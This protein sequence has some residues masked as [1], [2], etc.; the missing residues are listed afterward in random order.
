MKVDG[1]CHCGHLTYEAE[2]DESIVTVCHCTDCQNLAGTPFRVTA[3]SFEGSFTLLTGKP[4]EYVKT[5]GSGNPRIQAFCAECGSQ[6]YSTSVGEGPKVYNLRVG[7][8]RQRDSLVPTRQIW[9]RSAHHWIDNL[10]SVPMY[11][12]GPPQPR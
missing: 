2:I 4:K 9:A 1:G 10:S 11:Q 8:I 7:T 6:I 3:H 12:E 5:G